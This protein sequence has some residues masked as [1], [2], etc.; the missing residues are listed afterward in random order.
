MFHLIHKRKKNS[1]KKKEQTIHQNYYRRK[2]DL[3]EKSKSEK[4]YKK[5]CKGSE[6]SF[7]VYILLVRAQGLVLEMHSESNKF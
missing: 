6:L 5:L 4:M 2:K 3:Q 1:A 7:V